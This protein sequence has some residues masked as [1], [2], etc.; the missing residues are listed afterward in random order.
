MALRFEYPTERTFNNPDASG[1]PAKSQ[2]IVVKND[3]NQTVLT[4]TDDGDGNV[5]LSLPGTLTV[6]GDLS[7]SGESPGS[8]SLET[9]TGD[10]DG[11]NDEFVFSG[12]PI[13][14]FRNGVQETRLGS[15]AGSTFTF[16]T[17]PQEG[18]DIEG[19]V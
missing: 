10:V 11:V 16:D 4:L 14:V 13:A 9:P 12:P 19:L 3:A 1:Q 17:A 7:V 18:D 8:L 6:D 2:S 5:S 15:V